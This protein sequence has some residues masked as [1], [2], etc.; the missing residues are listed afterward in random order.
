M[1]MFSTLIAET[2]EI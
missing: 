2:I 1:V